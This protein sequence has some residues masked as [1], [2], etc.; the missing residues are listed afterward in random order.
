MTPEEVANIDWRDCSFNVL[1]K[2]NLWINLGNVCPVCTPEAI[3][4]K[5]EASDP[6]AAFDSDDEAALG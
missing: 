6:F 5:Q 1:V 3:L 4:V 2:I